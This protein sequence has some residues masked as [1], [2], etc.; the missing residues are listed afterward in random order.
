MCKT[1]LFCPICLSITK[2][3]SVPGYLLLLRAKLPSVFG[4]TW[5]KGVVCKHKEREQVLYPSLCRLSL[6]VPSL[7][8]LFSRHSYRT[9]P[10]RVVTLIFSYHCLS[11]SSIHTD[12]DMKPVRLFIPSLYCKSCDMVLDVFTLHILKTERSS[13]GLPV[14]VVVPLKCP[15]QRKR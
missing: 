8:H 14:I 1:F 4:H 13:I 7:S 5:C 3:H 11:Y 6:Q 15:C 10:N 12:T 9:Q 2:S